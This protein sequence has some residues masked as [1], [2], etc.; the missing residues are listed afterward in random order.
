MVLKGGLE[1][2]PADAASPTDATLGLPNAVRANNW[3]GS[4]IPPLLAV[5]HALFLFVPISPVDDAVFLL[6]VFTTLLGV[7]SYGHV[8][9][10]LFDIEQ[11]R[12]AGKPNAMAPLDAG[13]RAIYVV[14]TLGVSILPLL[15]WSPSWSALACVVLNLLAPTLYSIPPVRTKERG[16][17]GAL[18]D[19][20]GAHLIPTV[21]VI[22]AYRS[23]FGNLNNAAE[24]FALFMPMWAFA[25]GLRG[26]LNH[27]LSDRE[28]D[29]AAGAVTLAATE[30]P[31]RLVRVVRTAL[32]WLVF[33]G[34]VLV[35][36]TLAT[37]VPSIV[38]LFVV[39]CVYESSKS[40]IGWRYSFDAT[41]RYRLS[42]I[43]FV[44]N[45]YF[46]V[47]LPFALAL[48]V[49]LASPLLWLVAAA[50]WILF[51]G[52]LLDQEREA[53]RLAKAILREYRN[54]GFRRAHG[55]RLDLSEEAVVAIAA[56]DSTNPAG[57]FR[58]I[59][60]R[61][62]QDHWDVKLSWPV[63]PIAAG[64]WYRVR[65]T[66]RA[67]SPRSVFLAVCQQEEPWSGLGLA[68][69][70][71][72]EQRWA[73]FL[74][75]FQATESEPASSI[76]CWVG[77]SPIAIEIKRVS[78]ESIGPASRWLWER[79]ANYDAD[80]EETSPEGVLR[81][82]IV[83]ADGIPSG[84]RLLHGQFAIERG[85]AYRLA[86]SLSA[87]APRLLQAGVGGAQPP[88]N[89]LGLEDDIAVTTDVTEHTLDF[90]ATADDPRAVLY[91]SL[92][93][94]RA[95]VTVHRATIE[96]GDALRA[97]K[98]DRKG[99]ARGERV[100]IAE[101]VRIVPL[102]ASE[103]D[104]DLVVSRPLGTIT[105]GQW[106]RALLEM[107]GVA[108]REVVTAARQGEPPYRGMGLSETAFVAVER[109]AYSFDFQAREEG[110][111]W[112]ALAL[113]RS[114][115]PLDL[116]DARIYPID[117]SEAWRLDRANHAWA[118]LSARPDGI[119]VY[120]DRPTPRIDDLRLS[121][122]LPRIAA[123]RMGRISIVV[124]SPVRQ[125]IGIG[126]RSSEPGLIFGV[127]EDFEIGPE[128]T[129]VEVYF[130]DVRSEGASSTP[131]LLDDR[132]SGATNDDAASDRVWDP[133]GEPFVHFWLGQCRELISIREIDVSN[134]E[135]RP[136]WRL[137]RPTVGRACRSGAP[138]PLTIRTIGN[139]PF[140]R[141]LFGPWTLKEATS[142]SLL[143]EIEAPA[144]RDQWP[145]E[146]LVQMRQGRPPWNGLGL[147]APL[148]LADAAET[149]RFDFVATQ[150]DELAE[151]VLEI[152]GAV[153]WPRF[154]API[155]R[156]RSA[157][158]GWRLELRRGARASLLG[159]IDSAAVRVVLSATGGE[160][161][162]RG[163]DVMLA[164]SPFKV[165]HGDH[166]ELRFRARSSSS[167]LVEV[168]VD[169]ST[170]TSALSFLREFVSIGEEWKDQVLHFRA[171]AD[172]EEATPRFLLGDDAGRVDVDDFVPTRLGSAS[173][174][175]D[176]SRETPSAKSPPRT[177]P[178]RY[179]RMSFQGRGRAVRR[180]LAQGVRFEH[181]SAESIGD[182]AAACLPFKV[183]RARPHRAS[184]RVRASS[185]G[186]V[187]VDVR[188][189]RAPWRGLGLSRPIDVVDYW[190]LHF[191]D[192]EPDADDDDAAI[193]WRLGPGVDFIEVADVALAPLID[194]HAWGL[195]VAEGSTAMLLRSPDRADAIRI[196]IPQTRR[197]PENVVAWFGKQSLTKEQTYRVSFEAR[198]D[199]V[200]WIGLGATRAT[201]P[202]TSLG[203]DREFLVGPRWR[204]F[205]CYGRAPED[206]DSARI[207]LRLGEEPI[208]VE[209]AREQIVPV[210]GVLSWDIAHSPQ[211]K[212][213]LLADPVDSAR[214][215]YQ[216]FRRGDQI[217][218]ILAS[219]GPFPPSEQGRRLTLAARS[220]A[221]ST[222]SFGVMTERFSLIG[223]WQPVVLSDQARDLLVDI[224]A[225]REP[226]R[227]F[228]ALGRAR[229]D[230]EL[231]LVAIDDRPDGNGWTLDPSSPARWEPT[232]DGLAR[233]VSSSAD[234]AAPI[235]LRQDGPALIEGTAYRCQFLVRL[236][237][238]A[239]IR[240]T[241]VE[242]APPWTNRGLAAEL[243]LASR[244]MDCVWDFIASGSGP[245]QLSME[246]DANAGSV[247]LGVATI[248]AIDR[249]DFLRLEVDP[250]A[251]AIAVAP[252]QQGATSAV[253]VERPWSSHAVRLFQH[254][255]PIAL[256]QAMRTRARIWSEQDADLSVEWRRPTAPWSRLSPPE[257]LCVKAGWN[258]FYLDF[259][260]TEP[261]ADPLLC[262]N[263]GDDIGSF[264]WAPADI[265]AIALENSWLVEHPEDVS[266]ERLAST[267]E[268]SCRIR[269][270]APSSADSLLSVSRML[271]PLMK[272]R[273]YRV[274]CCARSRTP[275]DITTTVSQSVAPW[276]NRG[277][278]R[279]FAVAERSTRWF[280][281]FQATGDDDL[282]QLRF[283]FS[284]APL[285][286][287]FLSARLEEIEASE[288][289]RLDEGEGCRAELCAPRD[290]SPVVRIV[291]R[292]EKGEPWRLQARRW[293]GSLEAGQRYQVR[294]SLRAEA[295][296][297][298]AAGIIRADS[299][300]DNM[301]FYQDIDLDETWQNLQ[302]EF[303]ATQSGEAV[304]FC[305]L[306]G[307]L[308]AIEWRDAST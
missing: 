37:V 53:V 145:A 114:T 277:L 107:R 44:N 298:I 211:A 59:L 78:L 122:A 20:A 187:I 113:G 73:T 220:A 138:T 191:F 19:S 126:A 88:W 288:A 161:A 213:E 255:P 169:S 299:P 9:N 35:T 1:T 150:D 253:V 152:P 32:H 181:L 276:S 26:I 180:R 258:D 21:F 185:E 141:A 167:R 205:H 179:W 227:L 305:W 293:F 206:V 282:A 100:S 183:S 86:M 34:A 246:A 65:V 231:A 8:I 263:A 40:A 280:H 38:A 257:R 232:G 270:S 121:R 225:T 306:G 140:V 250:P 302:F 202:W 75:D 188:Q 83:Q 22:E 193:A 158:T 52:P 147:S 66:A 42:N 208:N 237:R 303:V 165:R 139:P 248:T 125:W 296:R 304:L 284:A 269:A 144:E 15:L 189:A 162:A 92:G 223:D 68:K 226:V 254:G 241:L 148:Y 266:I 175:G 120:L 173:D 153:E 36:S 242:S 97:W 272:D 3:W 2:L 221:P 267:R 10:D 219:V 172:D 124:R 136:R 16:W 132:G 236:N 176:E 239:L 233:V 95:N 87:Q 6:M 195:D 268:G 72:L 98:I 247:D 300:W 50:Q 29:I 51:R 103:C 174:A 244:E 287:E 262:W 157:D 12:Q 57:G 24:W 218:H 294:L 204:T 63:G 133:K 215:Y 109:R 99:I 25:F 275:I 216:V 259:V 301:G 91:L 71:A 55:A 184:F 238:P 70:I 76:A 104:D 256:G 135:P 168:R 234:S 146:M 45:R 134:V 84:L 7:A 265:E 127:D 67:A 171:D 64:G 111:S 54:I 292:A 47:W 48:A 108:P 118:T 116:F 182:V 151:F 245:C 41:G 82:R 222:V 297:K 196:R 278:E 199:H 279:R 224:P 129:T 209:I 23:G 137:D 159:A 155:L 308:A 60:D 28:S 115:I 101:G 143:L 210:P 149:Y 198:A 249:R 252:R 228:W 74:V 274:S 110:V 14:G 49:A 217:D 190:Q 33:L 271:Q 30:D 119:D 85:R 290:D 58:A 281:D 13:R 154:H 261:C 62:G 251:R 178:D 90:I 283:Q 128:E 201:A 27:Q 130:V 81:T 200:R 197:S 142:Y 61:P 43:P 39:Y 160:A 291:P 273:W 18:S 203:M 212:V 240:V 214:A 156:A 295:V 89:N 230:V 4:K 46:E 80:L 94:D 123:G 286:V 243:L 31:M 17:W 56:L 194:R 164:G 166:Y 117:A 177:I 186:K 229:G 163:E 106:Y 105:K 77:G 112:I 131:L 102:V 93:D 260:P 170:T 264:E 307:S 285:G 235:R 11:D 69:E 192:F 96:P 207:S 5:A 289:I 79:A